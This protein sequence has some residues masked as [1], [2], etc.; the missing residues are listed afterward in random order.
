MKLFIRL[1][2]TIVVLV[3]FI[4]VVRSAL[5]SEVFLQIKTTTLA[6]PLLAILLL[7]TYRVLSSLVPFLPADGLTF[8]AIPIG[9]V[10]IA[11]IIDFVAGTTGSL[12]A[13]YLGRTRGE[14][15]LV[16]LF[17]QQTTK[18][19]QSLE[20]S[21]SHEVFILLIIRTIY[22]GLFSAP[23]CYWAGLEKF[24]LRNFLTTSVLFQII[25]RLPLFLIG[26]NILSTGINLNIVL[27]VML[28]SLVL[29][30]ISSRYVQLE[31]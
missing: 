31:K 18:K 7:F 21:A 4:V 6:Y 29:I 14:A 16:K 22:L 1:L 13:Y 27:F 2:L 24:N 19:L 11:F 10:V 17:G 3:V 15:I 26:E 12:I 30:Y 9:G 28:Y 20:V 8:F 25:M 5:Q 23:A